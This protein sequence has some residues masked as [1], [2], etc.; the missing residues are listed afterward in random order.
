[1]AALVRP[2]PHALHPELLQP[3]R[4]RTT[5]GGETNTGCRINSAATQAGGGNM[6]IDETDFHIT[7]A[8]RLLRDELISPKPPL[9]RC[10]RCEGKL[11]LPIFGFKPLSTIS[12]HVFIWLYVFLSSTEISG[13]G[14]I[15][16]RFSSHT[17]ID[18]RRYTS[19]A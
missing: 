12:A 5:L 19:P 1:M 4:L 16:F 8:R 17:L 2:Q 3:S 13:G 11:I 6:E 10:T 14:E 9:L 7:A 15:L 18:G